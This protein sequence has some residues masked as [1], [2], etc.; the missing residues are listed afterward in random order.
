MEKQS[1][2]TKKDA[3]ERAGTIVE[4]VIIDNRHNKR[5]IR[6]INEDVVLSKEGGIEVRAVT[7]KAGKSQTSEVRKVELSQLVRRQKISNEEAR[8]YIRKRDKQDRDDMTKARKNERI[9]QNSESTK[10]VIRRMQLGQKD[11]DSIVSNLKSPNVMNIVSKS[12]EALRKRIE[13]MGDE[14]EVKD[15]PKEKQIDLPSGVPSGESF[16]QEEKDSDN[17]EAYLDRVIA[18]P[19]TKDGI[20]ISKT[21]KPFLNRIVAK[22]TTNLNQTDVDGVLKIVERDPIDY[23]GIVMMCPDLS[24]K[25]PHLHCPFKEINK[26]PTHEACPIELAYIDQ[27]LRRYL[28]D[29]LVDEDDMLGIVEYNLI[30]SLVD[31]D[32]T[33]LRIRGLVVQ[34]GYLIDDISA[35]LRTGG[36]IINKKINPIIDLM[37][38]NDKRKN[39]ILRH[40]LATP[41]IKERLNIKRKG[42]GKKML[43]DG[44]TQE[45][46]I[47]GIIAK[48]KKHRMIVVKGMDQNDKKNN[49]SR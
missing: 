44:E 43:K 49:K 24:S 4:K 3:I 39:T 47:Q 11:L 12:G 38:T 15:A 7:E 26:L 9:M 10:D 45:K 13:E 48:V 17:L 1:R 27:I 42:D 16:P 31:C 23:K 33:D 20:N 19:R 34:L 21:L 22:G 36:S 2:R 46:R 40:L 6:L 32:I 5:P 8:N 29:I 37:K 35:N 14:E 41:E 28:N 30:V 18:L 25:C